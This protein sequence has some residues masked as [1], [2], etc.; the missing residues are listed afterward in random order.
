MVWLLA[1]EPEPCCE[2]TTP[3]RTPA[4]H[5]KTK[6]DRPKAHVWN[7]LPI[8]SHRE[9]LIAEIIEKR[10]IV[11]V[12][13][14]GSGKSTQTPQYLAEC[15]KFPGLVACTQPRQF[16]ATSLAERVAVE[17]E[18]PQSQPGRA[19]GYETS[20]RTKRGRE[21]VYLTDECL[22]RRATADPL[23][24]DISVLVIDEAHERSLNT[25][26]VLGIAKQILEKRQ[27][28]WVVIASATIDPT[29]FFEF[30]GVDQTHLF[31][32]GGRTYPVTTEHRFDGAKELR[33]FMRVDP[34]DVAA[35][36]TQSFEDSDIPFGH[37]LV[38][39]TGQADVT[40]TCKAIAAATDDSVTVLPLYGSLP[41]A[42]QNKVML[43]D[44]DPDRAP[45]DRMCVVA[46]NMA[47]TSLTI[48]GV[49]LV[50]DTG[51]AKEA[52]FDPQARCTVLETVFIS[53]SSADQR[54]GRA[55]RVRPGVCVRMYPPEAISRQSIEPEILRSSLDLVC[56]RLTSLAQS[57]LS[58]PFMDRPTDEN[59]A[60]A[61]N[62][63]TGFELIKIT[64]DEVRITKK[65][66]LFL[67]LPT[68]PRFSEVLFQAVESNILGLAADVISLFATGRS[69]FFVAPEDADTAIKIQRQ[70]Q[71]Y[72]DD[73]HH[74][75]SVLVGYEKCETKA[76]RAWHAKVNNLNNKTM[77]M[78]SGIKKTILEALSRAKWLQPQDTSPKDVLA[79]SA[80]GHMLAS[81][82]PESV[83]QRMGSDSRVLATGRHGLVSDSSVV[84]SPFFI[85][86][87]V[88]VIGDSRAFFSATS[89]LVTRGMPH[90]VSTLL[91]ERA[92]VPAFEADGLSFTGYSHAIL[93]ALGMPRK[94]SGSD[95]T[96]LLNPPVSLN[97]VLRPMFQGSRCVV[98]SHPSVE[99]TVQDIV[100][101]AV[102]MRRTELLEGQ[103]PITY[104]GAQLLFKAGGELVAAAPAPTSIRVSLIEIRESGSDLQIDSVEDLES[105]LTELLGGEAAFKA[106]VK[107]CWINQTQTTASV[108]PQSADDEVKIKEI[109]ATISETA[110]IDRSSI[111]TAE[112]PFSGLEILVNVRARFPDVTI[113][114]FI[115]NVYAFNLPANLDPTLLRQTIGPMATAATMKPHRKSALVSN[116]TVRL[117]IPLDSS[118]ESLLAL[119]EKI[120][121]AITT[122]YGS[123]EGF[124]YPSGAKP[125]QASFIVQFKST[126][127]LKAAL[128]SG[129]MPGAT[130]N[131][132]YHCRHPEL[133]DHSLV[134]VNVTSRFPTAKVKVISPGPAKP[135]MTQR[136]EYFSIAGTDL[137]EASKALKAIKQVDAPV[138]LQ[139]NAPHTIFFAKKHLV[140]YSN[141]QKLQNKCQVSIDVHERTFRNSTDVRSVSVHVYGSSAGKSAFVSEM[142][143]LTDQATACVAF[144]PLSRR[145]SPRTQY[146]IRSKAKRR[147]ERCYINF[148]N[149][150]VHGSLDTGVYTGSECGQAKLMEFFAEEILGD[151]QGEDH[152]C[153]GCDNF[154]NKTLFCC[155]HRICTSCITCQVEDPRSTLVS[156]PQCRM[157]LSIADIR[158]AFPDT[159]SGE[160]ALV[161]VA[162]RRA[163]FIKTSSIVCCPHCDAFQRREPH[164]CTCT[165]C[166]D[167]FCASCGS[168]DMGHAGLSCDE[169]KRVSQMAGDFIATVFDQ[170][171]SYAYDKWPCD[172]AKISQ[173][174]LNPGLAL[175]C[176]SMQRFASFIAEREIQLNPANL[177]LAWHGTDINALAPICND[178]FDP[179][180]RSG[181]VHGPGTYTGW[182]PNVSLGYNKNMNDVR[183]RGS[184][185]LCALIKEGITNISEGFCY[186]SNDDIAWR[187]MSVL[188]VCLVSWGD[189][190]PPPFVPPPS[191]PKQV[192][193]KPMPPLM[194][195]APV[196]NFPVR[197]AWNNDG[198]AED[199]ALYDETVSA[200]IEAHYQAFTAGICQPVYIAKAIT[201]LRD[202]MKQDY[203][204]DVGRSSQTN[205]KTR[206]T[207]KIR[208]QHVHVSLEDENGSIFIWQF[209][210]DDGIWT[211]YDSTI[212]G[213]LQHA[214][215]SYVNN[216]PGIVALS[217]PGRPEQYHVNF[218]AGT[219]RNADTG[220][221][222]LVRR[223]EV[224]AFDSTVAEIFPM[225]AVGPAITDEQL[226]RASRQVAVV[227]ATFGNVSYSD[228]RIHRGTT[229]AAAL[230]LSLSGIPA[231]LSAV[232]L[233]YAAVELA[234][235]GV[236]VTTTE[237][238][239][240]L[241]RLLTPMTAADSAVE[242]NQ[243]VDL[244]VQVARVLLHRVPGLTIYGGSVRDWVIRGE[245]P[246][247]IDC[248]IPDDTNIESISA[249]LT[250]LPQVTF[251]QYL[252]P[253]SKPSHQILL[254]TVFGQVDID[255]VTDTIAKQLATR[256]PFVEADVSNFAVSVERNLHPK[257][258]AIRGK[259]FD[260]EEAME[261][262]LNKQFVFYMSYD[263]SASYYC[264]RLLKYV[265]KGWECLSPVPQEAKD[266][267]DSLKDICGRPEYNVDWAV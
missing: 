106:A 26:I 82:F 71:R 246:N 14:T 30:F 148:K 194:V 146:F 251:A 203:S 88:T 28:F 89:E 259:P 127:E 92:F 201:R 190:T 130:I 103:T 260:M 135:G 66:R 44:S 104:Q 74:L 7:E 218:A 245:A 220:T 98:Y 15:R 101:A 99:E 115:A 141:R 75:R 68:E 102:D 256:P 167:G 175:G 244:Q 79:F 23:L 228:V 156:C 125:V 108:V 142:R 250:R 97:L 166:C 54:S 41:P 247:D 19:V 60:A 174:T 182:T 143:R 223:H 13:E 159:A 258:A 17:Y 105:L 77:E 226:V 36:V 76:A 248:K 257:V 162:R 197:W 134:A 215:R 264:R 123:V 235:L 212:Q 43:F 128:Q 9:R 133:V 27:D 184:M 157:P 49:T 10:L 267:H 58:F 37:A 199:F 109:F 90:S 67:D 24:S 195:A 207:R 238:L 243:R 91:E 249:E 38:F 214:I 2:P 8:L 236:T 165:N 21:M 261:H 205:L 178:G 222:R 57:P 63:I 265:N 145:I 224:S 117:R 263:A 4:R 241:H 124:G 144:F 81:C 229:T 180:R 209:K 111:T 29:R 252:Q 114:R 185:I 35:V 230:E 1:Q 32:V 200:E 161:V 39:M 188:P 217:F 62:T 233:A 139:L 216:G 84:S 189:F 171:R 129:V 69:I 179:A 240:N 72:K 221:S 237:S 170:C 120:N 40:K 187:T 47:E 96:S 213:T 262:A 85:A 211:P 219:Q 266:R 31:Q 206:F 78:V 20:A 158:Q 3:A 110:S 70:A 5:R 155:G 107:E 86:L 150:V 173:V 18:G 163:T 147:F 33:Q 126:T 56:L 65:G 87:N 34:R 42:E 176:P 152:T 253:G 11:L 50:V 113:K 6:I 225:G 183:K 51:L 151:A 16:A 22:L 132:V 138:R 122:K 196:A 168:T 181:Q 154:A 94:F 100:Q 93:D 231:N 131:A 204:V 202:D 116:A 48:S 59:L 45:G 53:R 149:D 52:R 164:F 137:V 242:V 254:Q 255:F 192:S 61:I 169:F 46:T 12:A 140:N 208:R 73:A 160:Q 227:M 95:P 25:D 172:L 83:C 112:V 118:P 64:D 234:S 198:G 119:N 193:L 210:T 186:V 80:L 232:T 191:P 136:K 153:C 177:Q 121:S 55:G 239:D